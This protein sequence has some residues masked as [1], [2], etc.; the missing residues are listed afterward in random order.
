MAGIVVCG[1]GVVGIVSGTALY[2]GLHFGDVPETTQLIVEGVVL[3]VVL[4]IVVCGHYGSLFP[5]RRADTTHPPSTGGADFASG[6]LQC[7]LVMTGLM[8]LLLTGV[9]WCTWSNRCDSNDHSHRAVFV[10]SY[11]DDDYY[12]DD[13][14]SN[15]HENSYIIPWLFAYAFGSVAYLI[16]MYLR[17]SRPFAQKL[18][19]MYETESYIVEA[20]VVRQVTRESSGYQGISTVRTSLEVQ[21]QARANYDSD[22][23]EGLSTPTFIT[24]EKR[25]PWRGE[26]EL[27]NSVELVVLKGF[28]L[29]GRSS[30]DNSGC[31][32]QC[33]GPM[34]FLFIV[35]GM[36][37][38]SALIIT[39]YGSF[40]VPY[41]FPVIYVTVLPLCCYLTVFVCMRNTTLESY[42]EKHMETNA[43]V[44]LR[45]K[46]WLESLKE[47]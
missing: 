9:G 37:L 19:Q 46:T 29:T 33:H 27:Q 31:Y 34:Y 47:T 36:P 42:R 24:V 8:A 28:P 41:I 45:E 6:A 3:G 18:E 13:F 40:P 20:A 11:Y 7:C 39:P 17:L 21:Y 5:Q 30:T 22:D 1:G 35:S 4:L 43:V 16:L 32:N 25:I 2:L 12:D 15:H 14:G 44:R 26:G 23:N 38:I 10:S